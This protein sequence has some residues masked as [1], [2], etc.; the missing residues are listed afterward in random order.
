MAIH[1]CSF[2]EH[3]LWT[4]HP[5]SILR[6]RDKTLSVCRGEK[7]RES[8]VTRQLQYITTWY[9]YKHSDKCCRKLEDEAIYFLPRLSGESFKECDVE[10]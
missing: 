6:Y 1:F 8:R 10:G 7:S 2:T 5:G 4:F 3:V 9:I